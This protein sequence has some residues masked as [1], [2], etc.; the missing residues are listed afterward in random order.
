MNRIVGNPDKSIT[1]Q[2]VEE[3]K[4]LI[5]TVFA[6]PNKDYDFALIPYY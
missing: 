1:R 5:A 6:C 2:W 4:A 3:K